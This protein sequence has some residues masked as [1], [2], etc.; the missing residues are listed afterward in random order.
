MHVPER[1]SKPLRGG[2]SLALRHAT[3]SLTGRLCASHDQGHGRSSRHLHSALFRVRQLEFADSSLPRSSPVHTGG[4]QCG[5]LALYVPLAV[6]VDHQ[7]FHVAVAGE[8]Q[9]LL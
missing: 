2:E 7:H 4:D 6:A 3:S 9:H 1:T 5:Q 8:V